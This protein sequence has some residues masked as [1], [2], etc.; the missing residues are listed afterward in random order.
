LWIGVVGSI[1]AISIVKQAFGGLGQNFMNPAL[2]ARAMLMAA[3]PNQMVQWVTPLDAIATATPLAIA[4]QGFLTLQPCPYCGI[5]LLG[6]LE[7]VLVK[8]PH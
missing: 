6:L 7:E 1:F 2:A 5:C 4:K 8:H 3:W